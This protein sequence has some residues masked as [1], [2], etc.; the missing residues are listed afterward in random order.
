MANPNRALWAHPHSRS[1]EPAFRGGRLAVHNGW[2]S[3]SIIPAS[4]STCSLVAFSRRREDAPCIDLQSL[5]PIGATARHS[6]YRPASRISLLQRGFAPT[7]FGNFG[8]HA[9]HPQRGAVHPRCSRA[10]ESLAVPHPAAGPRPA[11]RNAPRS[12]AKCRH[13]RPRATHGA[14]AP[15]DKPAATG[16]ALQP[17]QRRY[18]VGHKQRNI[19]RLRGHP[20]SLRSASEKKASQKYQLF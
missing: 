14:R 17:V 13:S 12:A 16:P 10:R 5:S 2:R 1:D 19:E 4:A 11:R 8:L 3:L 9:A 20:Q 18:E 7:R 15:W 6:A